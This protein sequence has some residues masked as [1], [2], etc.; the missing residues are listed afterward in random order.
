MS[1][2]FKTVGF[3]MTVTTTLVG[4]AALVWGIT[5]DQAKSITTAVGAVLTLLS[6]FGY[7]V[8][9]AQVRAAKI[10]AIANTYAIIRNYE[11]AS[12]QTI[13]DPIKLIR[14]I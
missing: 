14:S 5:D 11:G 9:E 2:Q 10:T 8:A 13:T 3:W 7:L 6:Q 4:L 1:D 12:V